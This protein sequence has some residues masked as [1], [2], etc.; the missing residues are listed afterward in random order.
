MTPITMET[1]ANGLLG[2]GMSVMTWYIKNLTDKFKDAE[3]ERLEL[4]EQHHKD[5]ME[6]NERVHLVEL[7]YQTKEEAKESV[8]AVTALLNEIKEKIEK[9]SDKLDKKADK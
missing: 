1:L 7:H 2:I 8:Q 3:K 9:V 5:R 4:R 6:L